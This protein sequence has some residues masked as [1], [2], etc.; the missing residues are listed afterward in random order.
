MTTPAKETPAQRVERV[1]REK[2]PWSILDDIRRYAREGFAAIPDEDLNIRFKHWGIY[3]QGDGDG[4]RG[5]AAPYL[6]M[7]VRTPGGVLTAAQAV[8]IAELSERFAQSSLDVT[9]RGNFQLHW[10]RIE[11]IPTVWEELESVGLVSMG[12][13]GDNTRTVVGCPVGGHDHAELIDATPLALEIDRYLNGNPE[14][15]NFPRKLKI[16]I[17][18][19]A[20]WCTYPEINDIGLTA[21]VSNGEVGFHIR[22]GGGLSTRPHLAVR[23]DAFI[24]PEQVLDVVK[25]AA[26]IFRDSDELRENR[27]KAR[28]KFLFLDRGWTAESFLSELERRLGYKLPP[29]AHEDV[30]EDG[31]RDHVGIHPQKQ[32]GLFYAGFAVP[33]GRLTPAQLRQMAELAQRYGSGALR[34]TTM[35]NVILLDLAE[36]T[37]ADFRL[38]AM[39]LGMPASQFRRGTISCT[40]NEYCKLAIVETK[41]FSQNLME[42]M[43]RRFACF[44]DEVKIHVTGC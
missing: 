3:T 25:A 23:L 42:E 5:K 14:F 28:L 27:Q 20:H 22:V 38:E 12:S 15:A 19:C 2:A 36:A 8:K 10:L 26:G 11:D 37:L 24:R 16:S 35:Q 4:V 1:K 7:R 41:Q 6:M 43:E 17:T 21:A 30:P 34:L 13:C 9:V 29:A 33:A 40:G 44:A 32:A 31:Y 39:A 18:G